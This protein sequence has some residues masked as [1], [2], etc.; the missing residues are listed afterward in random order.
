MTI[1]MRCFDDLVEADRDDLAGLLEDLGSCLERFLAGT[2]DEGTML[3]GRR[4][5]A[6]WHRSHLVA[7]PASR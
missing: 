7:E 3:R 2:V 6:A 1:A 5:V 4:A